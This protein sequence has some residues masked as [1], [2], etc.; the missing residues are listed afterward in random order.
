MGA[1]GRAAVLSSL[2]FG[3][4][5]TRLFVMSPLIIGAVAAY[6][7]NRRVDIGA[8]ATWML[9]K[10]AAA[11]GGLALLALALEGLICI[12]VIAPLWLLF[13]AIGGFIGRA[14][15]RATHRPPQST[16]AALALVPLLYALEAI[17]PASVTFENQVS[18]D[19][20]APS[21]AVWRAI[22]AMG[23]IEEPPGVLFRLG[24]VHP[25]RGRLGGAGVGAHCDGEVS[26][27]TAV[28]RI[29]ESVPN[30]RLAFLVLNDVP[31]LRELSPYDH[32][33]APHVVGYFATTVASFELE[34][35]G[36]QITKLTLRSTHVLRLEPTLYWLPLVKWVVEENKTRVLRHIRLVAERPVESVQ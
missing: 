28:E 19:I 2:L 35:R 32:V 16:S 9:V 4:Y 25:L 30:H 33:H 27:G 11:L 14:L 29:T 23:R 7:G 13:S 18:I 34:D 5:G 8:R 6:I 20:D 24:L 1:S 31:T 26:T 36:T 22:T 17:F 15:A 3:A 12:V 10:S 21:A